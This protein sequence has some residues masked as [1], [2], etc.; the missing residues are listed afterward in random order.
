MNAKKRT[1]SA[2]AVIFFAS[3]AAYLLLPYGDLLKDLSS[4]SLV[5]ALVGALFQ[6]LRDQTA[7]ERQII[8]L[9]AQNRFSLGATSH[10]ASVAFDK[11]IQ[12]CET[13]VAEVHKTLHTLM[14]E[15]PTPQIFSHTS[16]LHEVQQKFSVWLTPTIEADLEKFEYALRTIGANEIYLRSTSDTEDR[17]QRIELVYKTLAEVLGRKHMGAEWKGETLSE[18]RA[19]GMVIQRLRTILGTE[20]LTQL[21]TTLVS[22]ALGSQPTGGQLER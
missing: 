21:R 17:Q 10:M 22:N 13:Y 5:A 15:G 1:Y 3:L 18:E 6:V 20:A 16:A 11:H 2:I 7:H 12:F 14:R 19:V 4:I 9:D 8:L